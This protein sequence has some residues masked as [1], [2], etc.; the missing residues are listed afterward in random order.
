[1]NGH[2]PALGRHI[3]PAP[4]PPAPPPGSQASVNGVSHHTR[5]VRPRRA[6]SAREGVNG[7]RRS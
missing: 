2:T 3:A 4:T 1:M 5:E 7:H 6:S